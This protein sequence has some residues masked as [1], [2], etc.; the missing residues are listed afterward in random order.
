MN[1]CCL[2]RLE[3]PRVTPLFSFLLAA[4]A[5]CGYDG[6]GPLGQPLGEGGLG[7]CSADNT[8]CMT[9]LSF[10]PTSR[11]VRVNAAAIWINESGVTHD[12]A[13]DTPKPRSRLGAYAGNFEAAHQSSHPRKFA[14]AGSYPFH[15]TIHGTATSGM[16]G[17]VVVQ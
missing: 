7:D 5:A 15:C 17:T 10:T 6:S 2:I 1:I 16:R 3:T 14:A 9:T 8:F 11:V 12:I 4:A 13:F